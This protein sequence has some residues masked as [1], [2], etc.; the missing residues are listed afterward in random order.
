[1]KESTQ[2]GPDT[3]SHGWYKKVKGEKLKIGL[4]KLIWSLYL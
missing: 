3:D 4:V 1:M 2:L